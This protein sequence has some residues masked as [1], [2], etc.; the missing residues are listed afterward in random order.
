MGIVFP[1]LVS[2]VL[3]SDYVAF[4]E[5]LKEAFI[6]IHFSGLALIQILLLS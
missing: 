4:L 5:V 6:V 1:M 2:N 3:F